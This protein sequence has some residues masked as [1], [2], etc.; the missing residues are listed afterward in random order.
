MELS[1]FYHFDQERFKLQNAA[2][3]CGNGRGYNIRSE[4]MAYEI[5]LCCEPWKYRSNKSLPQIPPTPLP[6]IALGRY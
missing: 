5:A 4:K 2:K 1:N 3:A 6:Q